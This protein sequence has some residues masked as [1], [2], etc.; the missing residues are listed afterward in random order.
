VNSIIEDQNKTSTKKQAKYF[1][2]F[3]K[4]LVTSEEQ[5]NV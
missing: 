3:L 2:W 1:F 5:D 4:L